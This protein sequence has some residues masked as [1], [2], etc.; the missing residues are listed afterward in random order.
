V[1]T[2]NINR[3]RRELLDALAARRVYRSLGGCD[4]LQVRGGQNKRVETRL[5]ELTTA[6][7]A[8]LG[9]D[10]RYYELTDAGETVRAAA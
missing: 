9:E 2:L 8:V 5:R 6:G 7:L 3:A 4:M 10:G 1:T